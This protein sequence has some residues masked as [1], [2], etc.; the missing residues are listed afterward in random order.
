MTDVVRGDRPESALLPFRGAKTARHRNLEDMSRRIFIIGAGLIASLSFALAL[1]TNWAYSEA[2]NTS[3]FVQTAD[4]IL[5]DPSVQEELATTIVDS[6][7]GDSPLPPILLAPLT[8][9]A[10]VIVASPTFQT[11]W[12]EAIRKVHQPLVAELQSDTPI[13]KTAA[14]RVD[15]TEIVN[16]VLADLRTQFPLAAE[17]LPTTAPL[18]EF[19]LIDGEDLESAR[20]IVG[21]VDMLRWI[22]AIITVTLLSLL[23]FLSR[24]T[25]HLTRTPAIIVSAGAL[26]TLVAAITIP[27]VAQSFADSEYA[28]TARTVGTSLA[29]SLLSQAI[30]L[31]IIGV[32]AFFAPHIRQRGIREKVMQ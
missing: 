31:L 6:L 28:Q 26:I 21:T 17:V 10:S 1:T 14:L 11:F 32:A 20:Q 22:L 12:S 18:A 29:S 7:T 5:E 9:T 16:A 25:G 13:D 2:L 24:K 30:I 3:K 19:E 4:T 27:S 8:R 23:T 15:L